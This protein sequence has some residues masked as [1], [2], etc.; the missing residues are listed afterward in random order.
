ELPSLVVSSSGNYWNE[1]EA[2]VVESGTAN[3]T[4]NSGMEQQEWHGWG[5]TFNEAGWDALQELSEADRQMAMTLLFDE[6]SGIGFDWGRIPIGPSDYAVDRYTL[7]DGPASFSVAR[8]EQ[9]LIPYIKAAQTIKDDVIYWASPWTPPPWMKTGE[10][11]S[12][13]YDKGIFNSA[14]YQDYADFF[15]SWIQAYEA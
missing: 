2:M 9:Y 6:E 13:G 1:G 5:G 3:F 10:T 12:D 4:V 8:D 15:V 7:S 14:Y 11:E